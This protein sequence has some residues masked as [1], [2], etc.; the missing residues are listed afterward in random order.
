MKQNI[1]KYWWI[2]LLVLL[3]A[4]ARTW[5]FLPFIHLKQQQ[6]IL[7]Q[8][9]QELIPVLDGNTQL[10]EMISKLEKIRKVKALYSKSTDLN[11]LLNDIVSPDR[12]LY[13]YVNYKLDIGQ[14]YPTE[15]GL[16]CPIS[17]DLESSFNYIGDYLEYLE[18][19]YLPWWVRTIQIS[20]TKNEFDRIRVRMSGNVLINE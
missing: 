9:E 13:Q 7:V 6:V 2:P 4:A 12:S 10:E 3:I 5:V 20:P 11:G 17:L 14:R 19:M 16:I 15:A 8:K 1:K 18:S